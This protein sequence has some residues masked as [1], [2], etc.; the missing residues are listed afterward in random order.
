MLNQNNKITIGVTAYKDSDYLEMAI[1]SVLNQTSSNWNGVLVLDGGSDQK[2]KKI[3]DEFKH[4]QFQKYELLEN[5]GPYGTRAK[6]I[7]LSGTEW[8]YQLDGDDIL[9]SNAISDVISAI[10]NNLGV[11][12]VYGDCLHFDCKKSFIKKPS[13][14]I[15]K[16]CYSLQINGVSPIK[17]RLFEKIGGFAPELYNNADWDFWISAYE[18]GAVGV[19]INKII[20]HRRLRHGNVGSIYFEDKPDNLEK[21]IIRHPQFFNVKRKTNARYKVNELLARHF[22]SNG[23]REKAYIYAKKTEEYGILTATLLEII[24]EYKMNWLRFLVRKIARRMNIF[25]DYHY[26]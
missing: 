6:A 4:P 15:E 5:K 13:D 20:Y 16:L 26:K 3:F 9:P 23:N 19:K 2:T 12:Y 22:R 7:E 18:I 14:D 21:I 17:V 24:R 11:D 1:N 25:I 10:E 8:Y